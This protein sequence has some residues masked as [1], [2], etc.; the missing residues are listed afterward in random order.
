MLTLTE[1]DGKTAK[2]GYIANADTTKVKV[3]VT[4]LA[5][6]DQLTKIAADMATANAGKQLSY[7]GVRDTA[8]KIGYRR[9]YQH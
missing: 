2:D 3:E 1:A 4:D 9:C 6:I 8:D 5:T 7:K